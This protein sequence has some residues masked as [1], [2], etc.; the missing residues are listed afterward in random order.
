MPEII[1]TILI[2]DDEP[3]VRRSLSI[4][5]RKKYNILNTATGDETLAK[6]KQENVDLL[7]L[8]LKLPDMDGLD[9]LRKVKHI[10]KNLMVV[11]ITA[12]KEA[13]TAVDAI[14]D[15]SASLCRE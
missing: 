13:K 9:V 5:L 6:V 3:S 10:D 8:D 2:A 14:S 15:S 7:L 1:P 12:I 4:I 11:I